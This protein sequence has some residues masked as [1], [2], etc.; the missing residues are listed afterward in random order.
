M[1]G[2]IKA[3]VSLCFLGQMCAAAFASDLGVWRKLTD[4]EEKVR[5]TESTDPSA[6][7]A[8][9]NGDGIEDLAMI[10]VRRTDQVRGLIAIVK[11]KVHVIVEEPKVIAEYDGLGL[12]QP[13]EWH[14]ICGNALRVFHRCGPDNLRKLRLKSPAIL[15]IGDGVTVLYYWSER[16]K[17]FREVTM[18]D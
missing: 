5:T 16:T 13:G 7:K 2:L 4:E 15:L 14:P 17:H 12:A 11:G 8:D 10:A 6:I 1:K 18:V 9:F 3:V